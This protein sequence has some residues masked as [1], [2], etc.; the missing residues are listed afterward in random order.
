MDTTSVAVGPRVHFRLGKR[1]WVRPG[2][3]IVR[4]FDARGFDVLLITA[5]AT[6]LR[7]DVPVMF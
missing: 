7:V 5:Q 1:G 6:A 3:S 4:G 2:I